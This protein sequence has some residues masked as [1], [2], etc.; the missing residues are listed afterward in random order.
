[1]LCS[2]GASVATLMGHPATTPKTAPT[3]ARAQRKEV[4]DMGHVQYVLLYEWIVKTHLVNSSQRA[5]E[6]K[7]QSPGPPVPTLTPRELELERRRGGGA[8]TALHVNRKHVHECVTKHHVCKN[9]CHE[10]TISLHLLW[11]TIL[12]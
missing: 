3:H 12:Q 10:G 6:K 8:G 5:A 11:S 4:A 9:L 7:N 2:G 1:M